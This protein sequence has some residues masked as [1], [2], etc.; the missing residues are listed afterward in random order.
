MNSER[1]EKRSESKLERPS[2]GVALGQIGTAAAT[3]TA[4]P[5]GKINLTLVE[6]NRS[7][8]IIWDISKLG[9]GALLSFTKKR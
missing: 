3:E 4:T 2:N 7:V 8:P 1:S 5:G 6:R 9:V